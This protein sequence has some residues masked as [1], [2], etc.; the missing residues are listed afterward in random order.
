M[1]YGLGAYLSIYVIYTLVLILSNYFLRRKDHVMCEPRTNIIVIIPAHNEELLLERLIG[2]I[3][4]QSYPHDLIK[5][6]VVADNCSDMTADIGR[7]NEA[8]VLERYEL[9]LRGKGY[10]IK[11]ALENI[12]L[13]VHD[14]VFIVDADSV[15]EAS[16]LRVLDQEIQR[17]ARI[18]Q[19]YNGLA[20]PDES[21]FTRIMDVSRTLGNEVLEPA[22]EKLGLSSHLMGNGMCFVQDVISKYGWDAFTVGEDWEYYAKVVLQGERIAFVNKARVYHSESVNLKQ[23]TSQRLRW[24]SGRFAIAAKYGSRMLFNGMKSSSLLKIDAAL[25]LLF[26]NPSLGISLTIMMLIVCLIV[27][28]PTHRGILLGWYGVLGILQLAFYLCGILYVKEKI[29]KLLAILF[30]P[31][32]MIW[33]S[34]LDLLS[35][36]G[37][38]RKYWVRTKRKL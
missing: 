27:P 38:G 24:S 16:A 32:F 13:S 37:F 19:C 33:K 23:A 22:K 12:N 15:V 30:A 4:Q 7:D 5:L 3:R 8:V 6:V 36:A 34:G 35:I 17:G 1:V 20:N 11:C 26:P 9:N 21:W 28:L 10:A 31:V 14:A 29:M 25:P 2:S 18:M